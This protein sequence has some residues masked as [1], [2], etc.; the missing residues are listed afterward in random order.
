ME[1]LRAERRSTREAP[2]E[3]LERH[4]RAVAQ[5]EQEVSQARNDLA[6]LRATADKVCPQARSRAA[7]TA[8]V[9]LGSCLQAGRLVGCQTTISGLHA[10]RVKRYVACAFAPG[11]YLHAMRLMA[12]L[13]LLLWT[14]RVHSPECRQR[15][16]WQLP[17]GC[18]DGG[19]PHSRC[20][21]LMRE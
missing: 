1:V 13:S 3:V 8:E 20:A 17:A 12:V 2:P 18:V 19:C 10:E 11:S 5:L 4:A 14:G 6:V 15:G 16:T 21:F 9:L 7:C